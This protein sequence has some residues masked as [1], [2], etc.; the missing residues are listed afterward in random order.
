MQ[1][2]VEQ[3]DRDRHPVHRLEQL[4]EVGPLEREQLLEDLLALGVGLGED[5]L[6]DED[7]ALAE[8]HVL[9]AGQPDALGPEPPGPGGVVGVVGV[10]THPHPPHPVGDADEPVD[11]AHDRFGAVRRGV[12][13][14]LEVPDDG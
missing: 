3:A 8:E 9:G 14:P 1:R 10:G 5:E 11:R 12:D 4:D 7:P 6:L 2:G 13:G